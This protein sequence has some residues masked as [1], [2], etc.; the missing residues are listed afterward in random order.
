MKKKY[1][2][3][4]IIFV[5]LL[6]ADLITKSIFVGYNTVFI[7]NFINIVYTQNTGAGF[8][9]LDGMTWLLII[10]SIL[11]IIGLFVFDYFFKNKNKLYTISFA[12]ILTG[13]VGNLFDRICFGYVRDFIQFGFWTSFPVFNIADICL[14]IG[15]ILLVI[16]VLFFDKKE[17]KR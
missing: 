6:S 17:A 1:L 3:I 7:P 9:L 13:A 12:L 15:T 14:T 8:N 4:S 11:L 5:V 10:L 16:F 2:I